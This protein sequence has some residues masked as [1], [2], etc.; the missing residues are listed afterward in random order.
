MG[1]KVLLLPVR[2][3]KDILNF[4]RQA[5]PFSQQIF[6]KFRHYSSQ[7]KVAEYCVD[8]ELISELMDVETFASGRGIKNVRLLNRKYGF[9]KWRKRKGVALIRLYNGNECFAE[10]HWYEAHGKG[11]KE[12]KVKWILH[13]YE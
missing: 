13:G 2:H 11:R 8:F 12:M 6:R 9:A 10:L 3:R 4:L 7:D 1:A 5:K